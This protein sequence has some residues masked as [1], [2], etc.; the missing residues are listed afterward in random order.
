MQKAIW[1]NNTMKKI[2]YRIIK[3]L[4]SLLGCSELIDRQQYDRVV[5]FYKNSG[6]T[7][8]IA[9]QEEVDQYYHHLRNRTSG[10]SKIINFHDPSLINPPVNKPNETD[11]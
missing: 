6:Y 5:P 10:A 1:M 11:D 3:T 7:H 4:S 8:I 9:N 2:R